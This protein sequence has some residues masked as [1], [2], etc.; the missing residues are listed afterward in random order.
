MHLSVDLDPK[1]RN[2]FAEAGDFAFAFELIFSFQ[3]PASAPDSS[4][5]SLAFQASDFGFAAGGSTT[6]AQLQ[7]ALLNI[8]FLSL[9]I[10]DTGSLPSTSAFVPLS[11]SVLDLGGLHLSGPKGVCCS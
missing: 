2:S 10:L 9:L 3:A 1:Q 4:A 6:A 7:P 11:K 8:V 5:L